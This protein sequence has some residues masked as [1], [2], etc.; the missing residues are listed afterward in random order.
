M[1]VSVTCS[2]DHAEFCTSLGA[3]ETIDYN[4]QKFEEVASGICH[5]LLI[6]NLSL[7][8]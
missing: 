1:K 6:E 5:E 2:P 3:I 7:M 8:K 4:E